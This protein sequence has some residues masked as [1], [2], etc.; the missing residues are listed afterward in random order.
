MNFDAAADALKS[1]DTLTG[2]FEIAGS[3]YPLQV[4][5]PTLGELEAI[6]NGLADSADEIEAIRHMV[7]DFL[8]KPDVDPDAIGVGKLQALFLG[9]RETWEMSDA[10]DNAREEMPIEG[11]RR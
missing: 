8:L 11:K 3:E 10:F 5:E 2:T 6:D 1:Q 4:E 7:D 9:M